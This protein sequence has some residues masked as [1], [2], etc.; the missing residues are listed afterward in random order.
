MKMVENAQNSKA[1]IQSFAD[2]I[3]SVFVPF[4]VTLAVMSWIV[5]FVITYNAEDGSLLKN[6]KHESKF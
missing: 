5:W 4:I 6:T 3:S 1:P 2:K